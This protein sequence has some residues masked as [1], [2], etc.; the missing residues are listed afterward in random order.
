MT[1]RLFGLPNVRGSLGAKHSLA[2]HRA[3]TQRDPY[4][5]PAQSL[6]P[7]PLAEVRRERA[8]LTFSTVVLSL[9]FAIPM[10]LAGIILH[11]R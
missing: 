11:L 8:A 9:I 5:L 3:D 10:I 4:P 6:R 1:S 2:R 7:D